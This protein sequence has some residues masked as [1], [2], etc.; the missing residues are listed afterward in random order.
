M[1]VSCSSPRDQTKRHSISENVIWL[2]SAMPAKAPQGLQLLDVGFG[3]LAAA[4]GELLHGDEGLSL[5]LFHGVQGGG[6]AQ[7]PDGDEGGSR[8]FSVILKAVAWES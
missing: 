4:G 2:V 5:P 7:A 6:L 3:Q 1:L 8:P